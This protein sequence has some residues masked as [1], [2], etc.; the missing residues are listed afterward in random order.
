MSESRHISVR[1]RK[2]EV[3]TVMRQ[4]WWGCFKVAV[5]VD[6]HAEGQRSRVQTDA[7]WQTD[8]NR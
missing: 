6:V 1:K 8:T 7:A 3:L 4:E 5:A 2:K